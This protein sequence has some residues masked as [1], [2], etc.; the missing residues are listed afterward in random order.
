MQDARWQVK[1]SLLV[2]AGCIGFVSI[3][4]C[5]DHEPV[6]SP[7]ARMAHDHSAPAASGEPTAEALQDIARLR[8]RT[9]QFHRFEVAEQA[10]WGAR[11]TGCFDNAQLGGMGFHYGN[12]ALIDGTVDALQPEL[13]LYEPQKNGRLALVAVEYIVPFGAWTGSAPPQL[14][15]QTFHRNEGFGLWVLHVWHFRGNPR[16]IFADWNPNVTCTYA[17]AVE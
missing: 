4:G 1:A 7:E 16:G 14:Y 13:L 12:P 9:A 6:T 5:A 8:E 3:G 10:G 15:G 2:I 17:H 11:I